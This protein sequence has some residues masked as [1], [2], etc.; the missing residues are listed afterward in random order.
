MSLNLTLPGFG[1]PSTPAPPPPPEPL[2]PPPRMVDAQRQIAGRRGRRSQ[3]R[4]A[5]ITNEGGAQ[6]LDVSSTQRALRTLTGQ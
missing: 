6:G 5:N 1:G 4:A 2:P 3:A